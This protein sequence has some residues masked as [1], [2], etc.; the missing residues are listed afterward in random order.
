MGVKKIR[1][2]LMMRKEHAEKLING[3]KKATI[4]VGRY[5]ALNKNVLIHSGGRPVA[6]AEIEDIEV[7]R[8]SELTDEDARQDGF[9]NRKELLEELRR[10][11]GRIDDDTLVSVIRIRNVRALKDAVYDPYSGYRPEQIAKIALRYIP[12]FFSSDEILILENI[13]KYGSIRT[14]AL[15]LFNDPLKRGRIRRV[16]RKAYSKLIDQGLLKRNSRENESLYFV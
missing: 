16:L 2:H 8:V 10:I 1:H 14:V 13:A 5:V 3:T 9:K 7:K 4:R 11:Y 6:V 15:K 12:E